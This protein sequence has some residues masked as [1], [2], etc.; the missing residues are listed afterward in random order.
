M[1][2]IFLINFK[3]IKFSTWY[4]TTI[5]III[6]IQLNKGIQKFTFKI[7]L[8]NELHQVNQGS[9]VYRD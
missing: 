4:N 6:I 9:D 7:L 3:D 5:I 1:I 8:T 2:F